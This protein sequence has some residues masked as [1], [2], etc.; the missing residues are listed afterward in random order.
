MPPYLSKKREHADDAAVEV[1]E[2]W[3]A[4]A[5]ES[6]LPPALRDRSISD[7]VFRQWSTSC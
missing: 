7:C 3:T 5:E 2:D 6:G 1:V 4:M